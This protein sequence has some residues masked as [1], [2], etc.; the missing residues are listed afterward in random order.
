MYE[1]N[2]YSITIKYIACHIIVYAAWH[3]QYLLS[4][5]KYSSTNLGEN[6]CSRWKD[7]CADL[8]PYRFVYVM[9]GFFNKSVITSIVHI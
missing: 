4:L 8:L 3:G 9:I 2:I 7:G 6:D 5:K 1:P